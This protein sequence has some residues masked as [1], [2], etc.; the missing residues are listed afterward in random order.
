MVLM[1]Q[2]PVPFDKSLVLEKK[3]WIIAVSIF[4]FDQLTKYWIIW[5]LNVGEVVPV[6]PFFNLVHYKN[7][8]AAFGMFH[9]SSPEF[10]LVFFGLVTLVFLT[11]IVYWLGTASLKD[12]AY[13]LG[14]ALILGGAL[15]NVK[16]RVIFQE[17]TDFLDFY[18][19]SY[20]WPAF[21]VADSAITVGVCWV[22]LLQLPWHKWISKRH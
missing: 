2:I 11:L 9:N 3:I 22:M 5:K 18:V 19:G 6:M 8:G 1:S 7:R 20:H 10:R 14:L 12:R 15:G 21:N 13:R 17:V 16:D 4:I